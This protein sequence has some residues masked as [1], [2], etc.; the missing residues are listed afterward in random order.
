MSNREAGRRQLRGQFEERLLERGG[1]TKEET[2]SYTGIIRFGA[3]IVRNGNLVQSEPFMV[4]I[5]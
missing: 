3:S 2:T 4:T 1:L 5:R